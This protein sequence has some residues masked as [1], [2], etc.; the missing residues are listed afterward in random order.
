M[1][2]KSK[3]GLGILGL[4]VAL[5]IAGIILAPEKAPEMTTATVEEGTVGKSVELSGALA[6]AQSRRLGFATGGRVAEVRVEVGDIVYKGTVIATLEGVTNVLPDG[7]SATHVATLSSPID[8]VVTAIDIAPGELVAPGVVVAMV[9]GPSYDGFI[10]EFAVSEDDIV[11]L[12]VGD[13][14]TMEVDAID[15]VLFTGVIMDIA[16][17]AMSVEGVVLY[18]VTTSFEVA[19]ADGKGAMDDVKSGMSVT[20]EVVIAQDYDALFIPARAVITEDGKTTVRVPVD[21]A[22]GYE[23]REVVTGLR[24][25]DG[26]VVIREGLEKGDL[27]I[28]KIENE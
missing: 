2:K 9:E 20:A 19:D 5:G 27:V 10:A 3:V 7:T 14:V 21:N 28:T 1:T 15:D 24:G 6:Y 8:G 18:A 12:D 4:V 23:T 17:T 25:D 13:D 22:D 16:P 11:M 26:M